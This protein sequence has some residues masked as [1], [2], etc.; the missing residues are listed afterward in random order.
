MKLSA[1]SCILLAS[2]LLASPAAAEPI[3]PEG[4]FTALDAQMI[5]HGRQ[6]YAINAV[7]FG[8]SL[9][10]HVADAEAQELVEQFLAQDASDD[11]EAVTGK[12][13][14]ELLVS[15]GEYGDLGFF[16][17]V[18]LVGTAYHYMTLKRDGA[19]AAEL[20]QARARV[21]R[22]AESWHLFYIVHGGAEEG[23]VARGI[24]RMVKEHDDQPTL[25]VSYPEMV[26]LFDEDGEP[27][28]APKNNGAYRYD[29]SDGLLP[30]GEWIWK[31]SCSK[32]QLVGRP[33][34]TR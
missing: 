22:A 33:S 26:P 16:G 14:Y 20:E 7:P 34:T 30:E 32:D 28:P 29:N 18:A 10:A 3:Y 6:F 11:V 12:H 21:V 17:G 5:R 19:P 4:A 27:L 15:Y 2:A 1:V 8:L 24:R 23:L 25:P 13:P 31:D 9:D